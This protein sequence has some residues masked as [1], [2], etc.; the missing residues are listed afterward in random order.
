MES[1]STSC[2]KIFNE[3]SVS[4]IFTA[5][6]H[7][8]EVCATE[9]LPPTVRRKFPQNFRKIVLSNFSKINMRCR[10]KGRTRKLWRRPK[11]TT[12]FFGR[13]T[14]VVASKV[15]LKEYTLYWLH[16]AR[17]TFFCKFSRPP[18]NG[19]K[20]AAKNRIFWSFLSPK[21]RIV[22]PTFRQPISVKV[23][24]K[25]WFGVLTESFGA[26]LRNYFDKGSFTPKTSFFIFGVY[27]SYARTYSAQ[28]AF[29]SRANLRIAPY[30][31]SAK[32][33]YAS[34]DL[35]TFFVRLTVF[36][37]YSANLPLILGTARTLAVFRLPL[38]GRLV[39]YKLHSF[40]KVSVG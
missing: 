4:L 19:R 30:S 35:K 9:I 18:S 12:T 36:E 15:G 17:G 8:S 24:H 16:C 38:Q 39:I 28:S 10:C 5:R 27:T 6:R 20:M 25:T 34:K 37:I 33:L 23:E 14:Y 2:D 40:N 1:T 21:Q 11:C 7:A 32:G 3:N 31:R 22:S 29:S 13:P 26:E